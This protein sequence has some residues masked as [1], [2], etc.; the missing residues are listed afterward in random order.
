[1]TSSLRARCASSIILAAT[2]LHL[3]V[4]CDLVDRANLL[5]P[6]RH[7]V[8][9]LP[10]EVLTIACLPILIGLLLTIWS[11]RTTRS[12]IALTVA[13]MVAGTVAASDRYHFSVVVPEICGARH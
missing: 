9:S 3:P 5:S 12:E 11:L 10:D 7:G 8:A 2:L 1:M 4:S 13:L 6:N